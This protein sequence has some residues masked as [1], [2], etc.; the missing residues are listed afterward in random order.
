[1]CSNPYYRRN[2]YCFK[3]IVFWEET[4]VN[5]LRISDQSRIV[6]LSLISVDQHK[7]LLF[8]VS[9]STNLIAQGPCWQANRKVFFQ[10]T[11]WTKR[12]PSN[13]SEEAES[14]LV[15]DKIPELLNTCVHIF[16]KPVSQ[17]SQIGTNAWAVS[18]QK[19]IFAQTAAQLTP[20][21]VLAKAACW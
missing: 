15:D 11:C 9:I 8:T 12:V 7:P 10:K 4:F 14:V 18:E 13:V 6:S 17:I 19:T 16:I 2:F 21:R 1:M 3:V 5:L 20:T